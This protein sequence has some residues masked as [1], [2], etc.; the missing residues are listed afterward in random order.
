[1]ENSKSVSFVTGL[2]MDPVSNNFWLPFIVLLN[3]LLWNKKKCEGVVNDIGNEI[4]I[5]KVR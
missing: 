2:E 5:S 4:K 1:V 3:K